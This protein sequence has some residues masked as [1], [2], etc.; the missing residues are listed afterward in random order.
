MTKTKP[1]AGHAAKNR[2]GN[3]ADNSTKE[4]NRT[5]SQSDTSGQ[6]PQQQRPDCSI[7]TVLARIIRELPSDEPIGN[8][9]HVTFRVGHSGDAARIASLYQRATAPLA[10]NTATP[11]AATS[12][13]TTSVSTNK[14]S[15]TNNDKETKK[16]EAHDK[17]SNSN[18]SSANNG[19]DDNHAF[20]LRLADGLG[21]ENTP[22]AIYALLV[23]VQRRDSIH[24]KDEEN[25]K[26]SINRNSSSAVLG[27]VVL[28]TASSHH[29]QQQQPQQPQKQQYQCTVRVE[30]KHIDAT[31]VRSVHVLE[32][33]I[34]VRLA[35]LALL[36]EC[37]LSLPS[38]VVT[39]NDGNDKEQAIHTRE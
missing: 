8:D 30:W 7:E 13:A 29:P 33:R 32:R 34:L 17:T 21:D 22:P 18:S 14:T 27:A 3:D 2:T 26:N 5:V 20:E 36:A 16:R 23:E 39:N 37:N 4:D 24:A 11:T 10:M 1:L 35:A 12:V 15:T 38:N 9:E 19:D 28:L 31:V 25:S 6:Q